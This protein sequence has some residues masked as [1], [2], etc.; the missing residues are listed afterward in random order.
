MHALIAYGLLALGCLSL[1][2]TACL[3][4]FF[5]FF[6]W[7]SQPPEGT[8]CIGGTYATELHKNALWSRSC[9]Q[10]STFFG[11]IGV[12]FVFLSLFLWPGAR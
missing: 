3:F 9:I 7:Q 8:E 10:L 12:V 11:F 2:I 6:R 4:C 5:L 1:V